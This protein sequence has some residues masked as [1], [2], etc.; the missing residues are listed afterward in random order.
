MR[1]AE[2]MPR[3]QFLFPEALLAL[4]S[5]AS[6]AERRRVV[7]FVDTASGKWEV[8]GGASVDYASS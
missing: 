8:K 6:E 2:C 5:A 3:C 1:S 4:R 7:N